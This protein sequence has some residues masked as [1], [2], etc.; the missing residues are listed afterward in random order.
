M[1][2]DEQFYACVYL[3]V[4]AKREFVCSLQPGL[5]AC[6]CVRDYAKSMFSVVC[7]RTSESAY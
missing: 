3:R 5:S 1:C 6:S 4:R 7:L 2:D